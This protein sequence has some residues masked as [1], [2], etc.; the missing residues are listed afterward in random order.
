VSLL[1]EALLRANAL[2]L[3][4]QYPGEVDLTLPELERLALKMQLLRAAELFESALR[5]L[6]SVF[7]GQL[8]DVPL[9][10]LLARADCD[11]AADTL[12]ETEPAAD[13]LRQADLMYDQ[14][15]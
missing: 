7:P 8:Q 13:T 9:A 4:A 15:E 11:V 2:H 14:D 12:I 1:A 3:N 6:V 10:Q 5:A